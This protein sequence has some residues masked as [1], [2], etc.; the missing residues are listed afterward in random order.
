[1]NRQDK[2][3][4]TEASLH[5]PQAMTVHPHLR[6]WAPPQDIKAPRG[7]PGRAAQECP[8][9][10]QLKPNPWLTP[11]PAAACPEL[12]PRLAACLPFSALQA[13]RGPGEGGRGAARCLATIGAPPP[14]LR[15]ACPRL[16]A[17]GEGEEE[18]RGLAPGVGVVVVW[19]GRPARP[20][21]TVRPTQ[22]CGL[23]AVTLPSGGNWVSA[24]LGVRVPGRGR[25]RERSAREG[26][27]AHGR[28]RQEGLG[29]WP[30]GAPRPTGASHAT[31]CSPW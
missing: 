26:A 6:S 23:G 10:P 21:E 5:S 14:D 22:R 17:S 29:R 9:N 20:L 2:G 28:G 25:W 13:G 15:G 8:E 4:H 7:G 1:M 12:C 24:C 30:P 16:A 19:G 31:S 3:E 18:P 11:G 27:R